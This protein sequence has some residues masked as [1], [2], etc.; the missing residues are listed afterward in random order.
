MSNYYSS[1]GYYSDN[2]Y[3]DY[4]SNAT[5]IK[6]AQF[7]VSD[8]KSSTLF[9]R[10]ANQSL[11]RALEKTKST[12]FL[13]DSSFNN[14]VNS[15]LLKEKSLVFKTTKDL[16]HSK[17][18]LKDTN[19]DG[20][21]DRERIDT[22]PLRGESSTLD[23]YYESS[24]PVSIKE[25]TQ[26]HK[27]LV[28]DRLYNSKN[29]KYI[30]TDS[31]IIPRITE[32]IKNSTGRVIIHGASIGGKD[33]NKSG[34]V[35]PENDLNELFVSLKDKGKEN[36]LII[37]TKY[38]KSRP[39]Q[40][41]RTLDQFNGY[42]TYLEAHYNFYAIEDINGTNEDVVY[43]TSRR[44]TTSPN[45]E[46]ARKIYKSE[47][48]EA[49]KFIVEGHLD[50]IN[51]KNL[52]S[53]TDARIKSESY[54]I[55]NQ[56]LTPFFNPDSQVK[57]I[58]PSQYG[59]AF[60]YE[61]AIYAATRER[62]GLSAFNITETQGP[63]TSAYL[64]SYMAKNG[65]ELPKA[66]PWY[67]SN[68]D[69]EM[70]SP[71]LSYYINKEAIKRG[72]GRIYQE[73]KSP[74]ASLAGALGK[75]LDNSLIYYG[76]T[77]P[78]YIRRQQ[79]IN[80]T[81]N[82]TEPPAGFFQST[83]S[84]VTNFA[85]QTTQSV[86]T[87]FLLGVPFG[88]VTSEM[89]KASYQSLV[90][91][92]LGQGIAADKRLTN[93]LLQQTA[94]LLT[95]GVD[96]IGKSP[97]ELRKFLKDSATTK[98]GNVV[99]DVYKPGF[100]SLISGINLF[101]NQKAAVFFDYT[102]RPFIEDVINPYNPRSNAN[103]KGF[104]KAL[105]NFKSVATSFIY[106][107]FDSADPKAKFI[108][109]NDGFEKAKNIAQA[110]DVLG[111]Y[112]PANI[113]KW[114]WMGSNYDQVNIT[115]D[116]AKVVTKDFLALNEVFNFQELLHNLERIYYGGEFLTIVNNGT[117]VDETGNIAGNVIA[118]GKTAMAVPKFLLGKAANMVGIGIQRILNIDNLNPVI[119]EHKKL[120][121]LEIDLYKKNLDWDDVNKTRVL[122]VG[123][124]ID[125]PDNLTKFF[126]QILSY[127]EALS[128][129]NKLNITRDL[130][131]EKAAGFYGDQKFA[132]TKIRNPYT[133]ITNDKFLNN[134]SKYGLL[135]LGILGTH[136]ALNDLM[137]ATSGASL[138]TQVMIALNHRSVGSVPDFAQT[139]VLP[140]G[141]I[142]SLA[143]SGFAVSA[144]YGIATVSQFLSPNIDRY[145]LTDDALAQ[146]QLF[147]QG[148][149]KE[150]LSRLG[151]VVQGN[152]ATIVR[153]K[154]NFLSVMAWAT[155]GLLVAR[156][157]AQWFWSNT[158]RVAQSIP[159]IGEALLGKG[160]QKVN[161]NL[162]LAAQLTALRKE[163]MDKI[164]ADPNSVSSY[165]ALGA[166]QLGSMLAAIPIIDPK[167][168]PKDTRVTANQSPLPYFQFF[169]AETTKGR[170]YDDNSKLI[171]S[172]EVSF[173][174]G[175]QTAPILGVN[176]SFSSPVAVDFN[177]KNALGFNGV[178]RYSQE[179]DNLIN[180]ITAL[181]EITVNAGLFT[182]SLLGTLHLMELSTKL[183]LLKRFNQKG[184]ISREIKDAANFTKNSFKWI[185]GGVDKMLSI[186]SASMNF[187]RARYEFAKEWMT[188]GKEVGEGAVTN[189]V[190]S[191]G[192]GRIAKSLG[193][194]YLIGTVAGAGARFLGA[195]SATEFTTFASVGVLSSVGLYFGGNHISLLSPI[196]NA[197]KSTVSKLPKIPYLKNKSSSYLLMMGTALAA[198][199]LATDST[200]GIAV[201]MDTLNTDSDKTDWGKKLMTVGL[202]T[203]LAG[204]TLEMA[205]IGKSPV[206]ILQ[207]Y[208]RGVEYLAKS[209][210]YFNPVNLVRKPYVTFK[211]FIQKQ[212]LDKALEITSVYRDVKTDFINDID[213]SN[214][215]DEAV[216]QNTIQR[217]KSQSLANTY[218]VVTDKNLSK[219]LQAIWETPNFKTAF[220]QPRVWRWIGLAAAVAGI[221]KASQGIITGY[222]ATQGRSGQSAVDAFY[223]AVTFEPLANAFKILSG[224]DRKTFTTVLDGSEYTDETG[225]TF[226]KLG[227]NLLNPNDPGL[228]TFTKL[229]QDVTAPYIINPQNSYQSILPSVGITIRQGDK[230]V[231]Y[232]FYAQTQSAMQD[233]SFAMYSTLPSYLFAMSLQ[234]NNQY[235]FLV[236]EG[237][238]KANSQF[239][240]DTQTRLKYSLLAV[241]SASAQMAPLGKARKVSSPYNNSTIE[242]IQGNAVISKALQLRMR[243][244]T[245]L[246][247]SRID[248]IKSR[249]IDYNDPSILS[250]YSNVVDIRNPLAALNANPLEQGQLALMSPEKLMR[251]LMSIF[252]SNNRISLTN[253][254]FTREDD[255]TLSIS[256]QAVDEQGEILG[257]GNLTIDSNNLNSEPWW[258]IL[259]KVWGLAT[260]K[261]EGLPGVVKAGIY[262]GVGLTTA[263]VGLGYI[264]NLMFEPQE[265]RLDEAINRFKNLFDLDTNKVAHNFRVTNR[266]V[267]NG[268]G[269]HSIQV[270]G[271]HGK[272][273]FISIPEGMD[274]TTAKDTFNQ[275]LQKV[276]LEV[277]Q[278]S[279]QVVQDVYDLTDNVLLDSTTKNKKPKWDSQ[280][281]QTF[282]HGG[283]DV[284][285]NRIPGLKE[286]I[287]PL[288]DKYVDNIIDSYS[289]QVNGV[290]LAS[291]FGIDND[292]K[293]KLKQEIYQLV[294]TTL[295]EE[296]HRGVKD[297][298][299]GSD[300]LAKFK[301]VSGQKAADTLA[302]KIILTLNTFATR[303][304][305]N[306]LYLQSEDALGYGW[307]I[308]N[309]I[310]DMVEPLG[311]FANGDRNWFTRNK[312][313]S[314]TRTKPIPLEVDITEE[315]AEETVDLL[316]SIGKP[317]LRR[318]EV[319]AITVTQ[320]FDKFAKGMTILDGLDTFTAFNRAA[321]YRSDPNRTE[322]EVNF[323]ATNTGIV[324]MNTALGMT[325]SELV[326]KRLPELVK[327]AGQAAIRKPGKAGL[328][329]ATMVGTGLALYAGWKAVSEQYNKFTSWVGESDF[330]KMLGRGYEWMATGIGQG[331]L[332]LDNL[333]SKVPGVQPGA[334]FS[335]IGTALTFGV[336]AFGLAAAGVTAPVLAGWG[337]LGGLTGAALSFVPG[338]GQMVNNFLTPAMDWAS[339]IPVFGG[340]LGSHSSQ[341]LMFTKFGYEDAPIYVATA[342]QAIAYDSAKSLEAA[343]DWSGKATASLFGNK[344]FSGNGYRSDEPAALLFG[345]PT[346][347][348]ISSLI[349]REASIRG[350]Y[351]N[352]AVIG[353]ITW[354]KMIKSSPNYKE[355]QAFTN[356]Q[357]K[358]DPVVGQKYKA[359]QAQMQADVNKLKSN[360]SSRLKGEANQ[361]LTATI[362]AIAK[363]NS[364]AV[365]K[366]N[367]TMRKS[368]L[369]NS[370]DVTNNHLQSQIDQVVA[371]NKTQPVLV[372]SVK[373]ETV[374]GKVVFNTGVA[375][376]NNQ[377]LSVTRGL[378]SNHNVMPGYS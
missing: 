80:P 147:K 41:A 228:Q 151:K 300:L 52:I 136:F 369:V 308:H 234:G 102:I 335:I 257:G 65:G 350:Q 24:N 358:G 359:A 70:A 150:Q 46:L 249:M 33:S 223:D 196:G 297:G 18:L 50:K 1:F 258:G 78:D 156:P 338:V 112:L 51:V 68:Y 6:G 12:E 304:D 267:A 288:I 72:W 182:T 35:V 60:F 83:L 295:E 279:I 157:M 302:K 17:F 22:N 278:S 200:F 73:E 324:T 27:A 339:Q 61:R 189:T 211:N 120:R 356:L 220:K 169:N 116:G 38:S 123:D 184:E 90:D 280:I 10:D 69:K 64:F 284:N 86:L 135:A 139:S 130:M 330:Y 244:T 285:N 329:F 20:V 301:G 127:E 205:D 185:Y 303:L 333:L 221:K 164:A 321:A 222:G 187:V 163:I 28:E 215:T 243:R 299:L 84:F 368:V 268:K 40:T 360:S 34:K 253:Y 274:Q 91:V 225:R 19:R 144:G 271:K 206:Q 36:K 42:S 370:K 95:I 105:D 167:Q 293:A 317:R 373:A 192:L 158:L 310:I 239:G 309:T 128:D 351:Y 224:Y 376:T 168:Q 315:V 372:K 43:I 31:D 354:G 374:N 29:N 238:K 100:N 332:G 21:F 178:L 133:L 219:G 58:I 375:E 126:N 119:S 198:S 325:L 209:Q 367:S 92:A 197:L 111:S 15:R 269:G 16:M 366:S 266:V 346:I 214:I 203:S 49:Y 194:G 71:G 66:V 262:T 231:R 250:S 137:R 353:R 347:N 125:D 186:P 89:F 188:A 318:R 8:S 362:A 306:L 162:S 181:G 270:Q 134:R 326:L 342:E 323:A 240:S 307:R 210:N 260:D 47:E 290:D 217:L 152:I 364:N 25:L 296:I 355:L 48:P 328:I 30:F 254:E 236:E 115:F 173:K 94:T 371:A 153:P 341:P 272:Q 82:Y 13:L 334:A 81:G 287:T 233:T 345:K 336:V 193:V 110:L 312:Q 348:M 316:N 138:F 361:V 202:L 363:S 9:H 122:T 282:I 45:R 62:A 23:L 3:S 132:Q 53:R 104:Q 201:G 75:V 124:S 146:F 298:L 255:Q 273:F 248:S 97:D 230:G 154:G 281:R 140:F 237:L 113:T 148:L 322:G 85:V 56:Q 176:I 74:L 340:F 141:T 143:Y 118:K 241:L 218:E 55:T 291:R 131:I 108:L 208:N 172:G 319:A 107:S 275:L 199:W 106:G 93:P 207:E 247:Y 160:N 331:I 183:P 26:Y 77:S 377:Q 54:G 166:A 320:A 145:K 327:S 229:L 2:S 114:G 174:F 232:S 294:S 121:Q 227:V 251:T 39:L 175:M 265:T 261:L 235:K 313:F 142:G 216:R 170:I 292:V 264:S 349:D 212:Y 242:Q 59:S 246:S 5:S 37:S 378:V 67:V 343:S 57:F 344:S 96:Q 190:A 44:P 63:A 88:I 99:K 180:H 149:T 195:D 357:S 177:S 277:R 7:F 311:G 32:D 179:N 171:R 76:S 11:V 14:P 256:N 79:E 159:F 4:L 352:Q 109:Q 245:E 337:V 365:E 204:P 191:K 226:R 252:A 98:G 213:L 289:H 314:K 129:S 101:Q 103:Y 283:L 117:Y 286:Q 87:Y 155:V 259:G 263:F 165:E 305:N 161:N 276:Q